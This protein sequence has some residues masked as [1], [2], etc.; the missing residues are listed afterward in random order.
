M[1]EQQDRQL[2]AE[3][4]SILT[5]QTNQYDPIPS[6]AVGALRAALESRLSVPVL[7]ADTREAARKLIREYMP[8]ADGESDSEVIADALIAAGL[9]GN[10]DRDADIWDAGYAGWSHGENYGVGVQNPYRATSS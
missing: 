4:K 5:E 6:W 1:I 10:R 3:V 7:D 8:G 9:L 2:I